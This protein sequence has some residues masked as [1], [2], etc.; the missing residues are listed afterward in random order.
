MGFWVQ[1]G[2]DGIVVWKRDGWITWHH[3]RSLDAHVGQA[4]QGRGCKVRA[5]RLITF[6]FGT[7]KVFR[8]ESI[9]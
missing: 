4:C 2:H 9:E 7:G 6:H 5:P 1:A 3:V 8:P